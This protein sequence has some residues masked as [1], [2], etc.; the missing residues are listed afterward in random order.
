MGS[1]P[2]S[3]VAKTPCSTGVLGGA[4]FSAWFG[5]AR[6]GGKSGQLLVNP[7]PVNQALRRRGVRLTVERLKDS[8]WLRGTLPELDGSKKRQRVSLGLK[9]TPGGLLEAESRAVA[10]AAAIASGIYPACGLPWDRGGDEEPLPALLSPVETVQQQPVAHWVDRFAESFWLGRVRTSAAERTWARVDTELRR[11]PR[12]ASLSMDLLVAVASSTNPGSRSRLEACKVFKRLAN[13]AGLTGLEQLDMLRTPYEPAP[14]ELPSDEELRM[15]LEAVR[16]HPRWG[17]ATA[18]LAAYGCRPAEV[19]SLCPIEDGTG[20]VL[21]VKRKRKQPIWRTALALPQA[22]HSEFDLLNVHRP[23]DCG[24][25]SLYDSSMAKSFVEQW[26]RWL[27]RN[28]KGL[29]LYDL[30][31]AWAVRSIRLNLNASLAAKC[32]GHSLSVHH[33][34]YHRWLEEMDVAAVASRLRSS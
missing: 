11:L 27:R 2:A 10:L 28:R 1:S 32:L 3:P 5:W 9:A 6:I 14:R 13:V 7:E 4:G 31:H 15:F 33:E 19:F 25:P 18:A 12:S 30:R 8:L 20:R 24:K 23:W 26:G 34:T 22:W 16:E 17:W 29:Q 21:T